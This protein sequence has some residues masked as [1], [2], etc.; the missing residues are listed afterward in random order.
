MCQI[1][2]YINSLKETEIINKQK[3]QIPISVY[4]KRTVEKTADDDV[5]IIDSDLKGMEKKANSKTKSK[6]QKE[7]EEEVRLTKLNVFHFLIV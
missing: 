1:S 5:Q 6:T 4:Y 7:V 3:K 2:E